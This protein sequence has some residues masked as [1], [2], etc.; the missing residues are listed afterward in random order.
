MK[1]YL[2]DIIF[3]QVTL[4]YKMVMCIVL[5]YYKIKYIKL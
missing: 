2:D 4:E 5:F 3:Y 1:F